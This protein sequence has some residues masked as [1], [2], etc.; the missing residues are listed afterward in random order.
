MRT[1]VF[2]SLYP[3]RA[4]PRHGI[5]VENR[6]AAIQ[7]THQMPVRVVAPVPWFPSSHPQ[8]GRYARY[9]AT[10]ARE[11]RMGNDVI[12]PRYLAL[13]WMGM[14]AHPITMAVAGARAIRR[15]QQEGFECDVIDAHYFYPDGVA[16]AL[17]AERS[18]VPLVITARGSDINLLP[19]F[20]WP[21]R[22]ILWAAARAQAIVTVSTALAKR[23]HELGVP[24]DKI[25]VVRNGVDTARFVP[26]DRREARERLG[27]TPG[28]LLVS[29][30]NLVPEKGLDLVLDALPYLPA[31]HLLVVGDG[32]ERTRLLGRIESKEL[33]GRVTMMPTQPQTELK[34]VYGAADILVLASTREGLPNVVLEALACG[35][36]VVASRVGGVP[37][38][39]TD[40]TAGRMVEK[41]SA[42]AFAAAIGAVLTSPPQ[43]EAIR[44]FAERFEWAVAAGAHLNVLE[45][46][47]SAGIRPHAHRMATRGQ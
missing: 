3:S 35:T 47:A 45:Q 16:A 28:P 10:A 11:V 6:L 22:M 9:A 26:V 17:I 29:V 32:P 19:E 33:S 21:R 31:V 7:R 4:Q 12:Y 24:G 43:S 42:E 5:F 44:R 15:L 34:W 27:L 1:L 18:G 46:A 41:R 37:E 39:I 23:L 30:G 38:I 8:F 20:A 40:Q 14:Y 36:P 25:N 2:T 13:P